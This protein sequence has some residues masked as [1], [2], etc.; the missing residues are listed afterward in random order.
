VT[1]GAIAEARRGR[2][3]RFL[4]LNAERTRIVGVEL[5]PEMTYIGLAGLD[6]RFVAQTSWP[7]PAESHVFVR[8]LTRTVNEFREGHPRAAVEGVGVSL[9][10]RVDATGR[11]VF[12]P[13]LPW[14][15]GVDLKGLLESAIGLPVFLENAANACVLSEAWFGRHPE[16]VKDIVAVGVSE[17]LGVGL[18]L[19]GQLVRGSGAMGG[20]FGHVTVDENGPP[21]NCGKRG[22]WERYA[23]NTAAVAFYLEQIGEGVAGSQPS[24]R[25]DDLL[26]RAIAG[27]R[28]AGEALDRQAHHLGRGLAA[29]RTG[30]A[31]EVIVVFGEITGAWDRVGP[32]VEDVVTRWSLPGM[33]TRIVATDPQ[34]RPR[35]RGAVTLV[36][37]QHFGA[38]NVA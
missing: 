18:L 33:R 25:Y 20:E 27:D 24:P 19:N 7:T 31:P 13:N 9:P 36:V 37:Q 23:S 5:R 34:E 16:H 14:L 12:A 30:L 17:G 11:T 10:G 26:Q 22:C 2:R 32:I 3:P 4:H 8:D 29:L 35:L 38:P 28:T 21:C 1:E 6:A 15:T